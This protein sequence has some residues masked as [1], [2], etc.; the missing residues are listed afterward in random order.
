[1]SNN[2]SSLTGL[3]SAGSLLYIRMNNSYNSTHYLFQMAQDSA[4]NRFLIIATNATASDIDDKLS[5]IDNSRMIATTIG[6]FAVAAAKSFP[7]FI[8]LEYASI[9]IDW[10]SFWS[11]SGQLRIIN[12]GLTSRNIP[13]VTIEL[14][15]K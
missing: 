12:R 13:N 8:R 4:D 6:R 9:D 14:V 15:K 11:G 10:R 7:V 3:A 1:S 2:T 5:M